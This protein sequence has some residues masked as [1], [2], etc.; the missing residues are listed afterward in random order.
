MTRTLVL[1]GLLLACACG[2]WSSNDGPPGAGGTGGSSGQ[3]PVI[4]H[5]AGLRVEGNQIVDADRNRLMLRG[6]NRSGTEY[7]CVDNRGIFDG[8]DDEASVRAMLEWK[9]NAVRVP[10]NESC[11]LGATGVS[12]DYSGEAYKRSIADYV[13]LL[14]R[15]GI[16]PILDLHWAAP[17]D[18]PAHGLKPMPNLDNSPRF[19][20]DVARTFLDDDGVILEP[21][22]EPFPASNADTD[23]A[24][25]CWRD[26][27][28]QALRG[29][30]YTAA[31]MQSLVTAI[32]DTGS[33][34]L[35]L[36]G[37]VQFS[38]DLSQWLEHKPSDPV[39]NVAAAWHVYNFNECS[40]R[41][42]WNEEAGSVWAE[43]PV[44]ATEIGQSDCLGDSF[45]KPLMTYLDEKSSGYF[46][47]SW[48]MSTEECE[49]RPISGGEG[50]PWFLITN[51][52]NPKPGSDYART[53]YEH[54]Q[55]VA[56]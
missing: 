20:A 5:P 14:H 40:N 39:N 30:T 33:R 43:V 6:I 35:L 28:E 54:V 34:H 36:L 1:V 29:S 3:W 23:A 31:G 7:M 27:C 11:W 4:P 56:P 18:E 42:C 15:A 26:G 41:D 10:L 16:V 48:N 9:I 19:W 45:L 47:W 32:R 52:E 51:Y 8:P 38:N 25:E 13:E 22:N 12:E 37:G 44:V 21:Y 24:W 46:A 50:R 49:P 55:E 53:F 17:G 2:G